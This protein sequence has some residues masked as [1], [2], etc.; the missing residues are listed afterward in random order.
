MLAALTVSM[1]FATGCA[2]TP[3][4]PAIADPATGVMTP[5]RWVW[6]EL[7]TDDVTAAKNFYGEVFDWEFEEVGEGKDAYTLIRAGGRPIAGILHYPKGTA[8]SGQAG[9]WI[10]LMSVPDVARAA[11]QASDAGGEVIVA[12]TLLKGRGEV[13]LLA[14][15]EKAYFGVIRSDSGD[16]ADAFPPL[17]SWL[18]AELWAK[19]ANQMAEFYGKIG[20]YSV[21]QAES[22]TDSTELYLVAGDYPRAGIIELQREDL[23][24]TWLPY[25]RIKDINQTLI[26]VLN[27]EGYLVVEPDPTIRN[28]KVAV[29]LDP[30][31]AAVGVAEWPEEGLRREP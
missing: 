22:G 17:N 12:P 13:A 10:G 15:P 29:F 1:T 6:A 2:T 14:D 16:P 7:F 18:W 3:R 19:D 5:G 11:Q 30:L 24:S 4:W 26:R 9:R 25:I 20:G 8:A 28:G 31:G 23:P 21:Q 27:A